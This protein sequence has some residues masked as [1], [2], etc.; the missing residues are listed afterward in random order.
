M[1]G[2]MLSPKQ[3]YRMNAASV[4]L[5]IT[6]SRKRVLPGGATPG[7]VKKQR[8]TEQQSMQQ[9]LLDSQVNS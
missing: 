5:Y 1:L 2:K 4:C 3:D 6:G 9:Q 7:Q 8:K